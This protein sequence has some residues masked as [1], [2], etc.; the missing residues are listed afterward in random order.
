MLR[1]D[2][3]LI[4]A[5]YENEI[6]WQTTK[7]FSLP[8][9]PHRKQNSHYQNQEIL[10]SF[11]FCYY[12]LLNRIWAEYTT[13]VKSI[14]EILQLTGAATAVPLRTATIVW[15][16]TFWYRVN[17]SAISVYVQTLGI[18]HAQTSGGVGWPC[19]DWSFSWSDETG[20]II[21]KVN[22]ISCCVPLTIG[23]RA[24]SDLGGRRPVCPKKLRSAPLLDC[25]NQLFTPSK[26][27]KKR[28]FT[29]V[30]RHKIVRNRNSF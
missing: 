22:K 5:Y 2:L 19:K 7:V 1:F 26:C 13:L 21:N 3:R 24:R 14:N 15:A 4:T 17:V 23:V 8:C 16:R 29:I 18:P 9:S 6:I 20:W 27:T 10:F 30:E 12:V 28:A 25:R 11:G